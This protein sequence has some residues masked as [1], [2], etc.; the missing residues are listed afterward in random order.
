[1]LFKSRVF[2]HAGVSE[3][4]GWRIIK[5]ARQRQ[6]H[7]DPQLPE[8]RGR[9]K[10]LQPA[11][12]Q[13][14][15]KT[16]W[17]RGLEA[18]ALTWQSLAVESGIQVDCSWRTIQRAMGSIGWRKCVACDIG[19]VSRDIAA[20]RYD[21]RFS[22]EVHF[23]LGPQG[24]LRIIRKPGERY[25][26]DCIQEGDSPR[27]KDLKRLHAWAAVGYG[28]KSNL[29]FYEVPTNKNGKMSQQVYLDQIL[30]LV[31]GSWIDNGEQFVLEEDGD[32]GH[33]P[34]GK[35]IVKVWKEER[36]F[37]RY[38]NTPGSPDLSIIENCWK[39]PKAHIANYE[40]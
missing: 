24:K 13:A 5:D 40:T 18:R 32:S 25:C 15:E 36:G 37:K 1:P 23:S 9:R 22:D 27:E 10:L 12:L 38:F 26:P 33:R 7:H 8:T 3:R 19:W 39:V 34:G 2:H 31:V 28:F 16:L 35:N 11:D 14:M 17:S 29:I 6:R 4:Q 21:I 30:K 20:R